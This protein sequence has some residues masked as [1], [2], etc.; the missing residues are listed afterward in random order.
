M[1]A[2]TYIQIFKTSLL[3]VMVLAVFVAVISRTGWN[4]IG[5]MLDAT[6][7][8]GAGVVEPDRSDLT[9]SVNWIS[10]TIG[11]TLGIMGLPHVMLRFLTVRDARAAR[12]SAA[13]AIG[14]FT[15]F[16][17]MLPIFGY[18]A[19]NEIGEKAIVAANPAGNSAGPMLAQEVGGDI[20]YALVAGVTIATILAVLAGMA[21]AISG[22]VAHDLYTNVIKKGHVDERG[23]L[24]SGRLAGAVSAAIAIV[25]A[26]GA[27]D[28]NIANVANIAFAIA[29]ST[30][31]PT[32]LLTLYWRRFNQTGA[33][34]AMVGGLIV[35]LGLVL[36]GPDVLG[37]DDAIFPLA[38]PALVSVPA[39]FLLA[40]VGSKFGAGRVGS[41]GMPYDEFERRAFAP[42]DDTREGG[43]FTRRA[44]EPE[45]VGAV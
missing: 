8:F 44:E 16:F 14:I 19:L 37:K 43:R 25:L 28:L 11:L 33:L 5:P 40:Y 42:E 9:E 34:F 41:T 12:N 24:V 45:R 17:L 4:P 29:A 15:V 6:K 20:L 22:A 18:A 3:A 39:G 31:M 30:T 23:Q 26:F 27:K 38:I 32:L 35:S 21:I 1:V 7:Q 13:V 10:L 36:L 2:A